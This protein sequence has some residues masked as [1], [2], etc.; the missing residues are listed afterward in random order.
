MFI[1]KVS[2]KTST[3]IG[4][5][6]VRSTALAVAMKVISGTITSSPYPIPMAFRAK[7]IPA[8]QLVVAIAYLAFTNFAIFFQIFLPISLVDVVVA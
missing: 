6:P 4:F 7:K 3:N 5:A 8:V 1:F 2:G